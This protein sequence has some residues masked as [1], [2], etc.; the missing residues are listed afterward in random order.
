VVRVRCARPGSER[1]GYVRGCGEIAAEVSTSL[2]A[3]RPLRASV[4]AA[5]APVFFV[6][7]R[8]MSLTGDG[9]DSRLFAAH[10]KVWSFVKHDWKS[11]FAYC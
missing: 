10:K 11:S 3:A 1:C 6:F 9:S 7:F 8:A 4:P 2:R 5:C